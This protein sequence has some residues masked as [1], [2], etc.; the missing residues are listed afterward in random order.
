MKL[1]VLGSGTMLPTSR[2]SPSA[3]LL[4]TEK[5]RILLD[6]GHGTLA[7][8]VEL[9]IDPRDITA[10]FASHFHT[11]HIGDLFNLV[12]ARFVG[13]LYQRREHRLLTLIGPEG[14]EKRYRK[15]RE[16]SWPELGEEY[17]LEFWEGTLASTIADASLQTFPVA[18]VPWF[19][20]VGI[21]L[22][23][24]G[25]TIVYPGDV[26]SA[27]PL[28]DLVERAKNAHLLIIEAGYPHR[29]PNHFTLEQAEEVARLAN[30]E[31]VLIVHM[32]PL[33]EEEE[34]V[35]HFVSTRD[36]FI[37][38]EDKVFLYL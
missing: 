9:G 16:I 4:E 7:R 17:P 22:K 20:S 12:H 6:C 35:A 30:V 37:V 10:I 32:R 31:R 26:G 29:T 5:A 8:L 38:A 28:D 1:V 34:R 27:H 11:D 23:I 33:P 24:K 3:F 25:K 18:H 21:R 19:G 2:R 15:W 14:L 36:T 13:D